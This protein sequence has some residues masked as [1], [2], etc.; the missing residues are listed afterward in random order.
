MRTDEYFIEI[1]LILN[2]ADEY[3]TLNN[4]KIIKY[5]LNYYFKNL[6]K[7]KCKSLNIL[8]WTIYNSCHSYVLII[9][10]L[11]SQ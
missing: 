10:L 9:C 6:C 5:L 11:I 8:I 4:I 1:L 7:I 3:L 2:N